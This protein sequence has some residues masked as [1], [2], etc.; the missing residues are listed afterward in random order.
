MII[1]GDM[2]PNE[3]GQKVIGEAVWLAIEEN[4]LLED[5]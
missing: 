1:P 3:E 5:L 2:H 4:G